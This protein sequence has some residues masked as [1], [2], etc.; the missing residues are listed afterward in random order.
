MKKVVLKTL[1]STFII[2][3]LLGIIIIFFDLWGDITEKVLLSTAFIFCFSVSGLCCSITYEKGINKKISV[4]GILISIISCIYLLLLAWELIG[5]NLLDDYIH[6]KL[7]LASFLLSFSSGHICL[8]L[9]IN[10]EKKI[11]TYIKQCTILLVLLIDVL[12]LFEL[13]TE[14][15]INWKLLAILGILTVR[16]TIVTPLINKLNNKD[17]NKYVKLED[18]EK[19]KTKILNK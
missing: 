2:G 9:L 19:E 15:V 18:F 17:D 7:I 8:M 12:V 6:W 5:Y 11:V 13:V 14:I 4:I 3:A 16:G 10:T 1:I